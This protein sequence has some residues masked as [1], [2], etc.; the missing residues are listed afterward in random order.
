[1]ETFADQAAIAIENARLLTELQT[2]NA[3]LTEALEQQTATAEIL[4]V[5]SRSPTDVQPVFDTVAESA[6][7]LCESFDAAIYRPEGD[8]LLLVAHHGA[9]PLGPIGEDRKSVV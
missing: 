6:A 4:R 7:R 5:I 1:M 9:I 2:K 8:R 3:D